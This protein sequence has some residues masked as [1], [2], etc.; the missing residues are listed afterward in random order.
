[1][2]ISFFALVHKE[3]FTEEADLTYSFFLNPNLVLNKKNNK[4]VND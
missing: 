4:F 1:M 2:I 3:N